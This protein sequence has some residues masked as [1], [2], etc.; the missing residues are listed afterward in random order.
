MIN[1]H[2][3]EKLL[4]FLAD[5]PRLP[6]R[7]NFDAPPPGHFWDPQ[8]PGYVRQRRG[9]LRLLADAWARWKLKRDPPGAADTGGD[10]EARAKAWTV[11][12][13]NL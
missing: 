8:H 10:V 9:K 3:R 2:S 1:E 13:A 11:Y 5:P 6:E 4:G 7:F 12:E